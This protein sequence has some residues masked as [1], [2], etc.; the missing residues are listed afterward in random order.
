MRLL[1]VM[2]TNETMFSLVK[3]SASKASPERNL[4]PKA[5]LHFLTV[6]GCRLF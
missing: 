3:L 6:P 5:S 1:P 2:Q 4:T